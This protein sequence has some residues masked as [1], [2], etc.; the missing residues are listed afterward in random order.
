MYP[1]SK[2]T[3]PALRRSLVGPG[4][5]KQP[6]WLE[7]ASSC[8]P[9]QW[10]L[11]SARFWVVRRCCWQ[12]HGSCAAVAKFTALIHSM[13]LGMPIRY[14]SIGPSLAHRRNRFDNV[15]ISISTEPASPTGCTCIMEQQKQLRHVGEH[16]SKCSSSTATS[17]PKARVWHTTVGPHGSKREVSSRCTIRRSA[18]MAP[19]MTDTGVWC[20]KV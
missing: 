4:M 16:Q 3:L 1:G 14:R 12:E 11:R 2:S 8:R 5:R 9:K 10:W 7:S 19:D 18:Y 17:H 15:L 13:R 20:W 6:C